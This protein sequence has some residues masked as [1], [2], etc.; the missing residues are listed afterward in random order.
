MLESNAKLVLNFFT[1]RKKDTSYVKSL[2]VYYKEKNISN[3]VTFA[4]KKH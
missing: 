1:L 3:E 2:S 4:A